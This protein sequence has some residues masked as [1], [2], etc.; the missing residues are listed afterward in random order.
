MSQAAVCCLRVGIGPQAL[1]FSPG[2]VSPVPYRAQSLLITRADGRGVVRM[3]AHGFALVGLLNVPSR[4][5]DSGKA[6]SMRRV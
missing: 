1:T 5:V 2:V 4:A 6:T 3:L